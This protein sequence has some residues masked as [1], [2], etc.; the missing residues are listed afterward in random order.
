MIEETD[1]TTLSYNLL[2]LHLKVGYQ[3][4]PFC[5]R[6]QKFRVLNNRYKCFHPECQ[7]QGTIVDLVQ[8]HKNCSRSKAIQ[9]VRGEDFQA[10]DAWKKRN[11]LLS[12]VF[13]SYQN[14]LTD[15]CLDFLNQR[16][17]GI[18][19]ESVEFGFARGSQYLQS[20]GFDL[21]ELVSLGL[22]YS[23]GRE[24]FRDRVIF[25]I[26]DFKSR[27]VH[28]Q[29]RSIHAEES[30]RWLSTPSHFNDQDINPITNYLFG[31]NQHIDNPPEWLFLAEGISD[32]LTLIELNVPCV[33]CFGVQV[34]LC[35]FTALFEKATNLVVVLDNDVYP[36][37]TEHAGLYKS[38]TPML[39][40]LTQLQT[41][42][43]QLKIWCAPPP[44]IKGIKDVNNWYMTEKLTPES[45]AQG[46]KR[47]SQTLFDFAL[48]TFRG[49]REY[50]PLLL[51]LLKAQPN[52]QRRE[53]Y[54]QILPTDI[55]SY[56]LEVYG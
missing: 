44:N 1:L 20:R 16:G 24:F 27:L 2:D 35:R 46:I 7:Q 54:R 52:S 49:H 53:T 48:N 47:Q 34:N 28:L 23:D 41:A 31:G 10:R 14:G 43:P 6:D 26:R 5:K 45:F 17:Y 56:L 29:G 51:R 38:W 13:S 18:C 40:S 32:A 4:C 15:E 21:A 39:E 55:V 36:L 22:A 37:M 33:A 8:W 11:H 9:L 30:V 12:Q 50:H 3:K 42:F 25:G 19:L